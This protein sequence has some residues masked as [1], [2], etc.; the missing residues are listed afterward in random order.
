MYGRK[1]DKKIDKEKGE[2][3]RGEKTQNKNFK[4]V[5]LA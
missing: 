1:E 3:R 4:I 2:K 5:M